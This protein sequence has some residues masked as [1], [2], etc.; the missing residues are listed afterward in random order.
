VAPACLDAA[1]GDILSS[2]PP[3]CPGDGRADLT[4]QLGRGD[5]GEAQAA[6]SL[7]KY[8]AD[9]LKIEAKLFKS[10]D[11]HSIPAGHPQYGPSAGVTLFT[12]C[13]VLLGRRVATTW[14]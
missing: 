7:V 14:R 6:L 4:G 13:V 1:G 11:I 9:K 5:E 8:R 3:A 2:R 10:S 12:A